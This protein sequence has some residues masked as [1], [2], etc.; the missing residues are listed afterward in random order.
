M[1]TEVVI[2]DKSYKFECTPNEEHNLHVAAKML[3]SKYRETRLAMPRLESDRIGAMVA[4]NLVLEHAKLEHQFRAFSDEIAKEKH[5]ARLIIQQLT[6]KL[7]EALV[8][9]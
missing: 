7:E 6:D 9:K 5:Q 4:F 2:F 1:P 3:D 8:A